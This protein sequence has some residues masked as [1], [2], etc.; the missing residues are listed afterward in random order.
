MTGRKK[1]RLTAAG[2]CFN[3]DGM[4]VIKRQS[5]GATGGLR[6]GETGG[7]QSRKVIEVRDGLHQDCG[8]VVRFVR[9][10]MCVCVHVLAESPVTGEQFIACPLHP[11]PTES[12]GGGCLSTLPTL[13]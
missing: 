8:L 1:Q 6:V 4:R 3:S 13:D 7:V 9:V 10:Y 2:H 12:V 11:P 5:H